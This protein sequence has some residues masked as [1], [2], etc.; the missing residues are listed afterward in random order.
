MKLIDVHSQGGT[1]KRCGKALVNVAL[2]E[3]T[4]NQQT[5]GLD[6]LS[7]VNSGGFADKTEEWKFDRQLRLAKSS[8]RML[9]Q[10]RRA[11]VGGS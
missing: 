7:K 11:K 5:V 1:C 4:E 10:I 6:C 2:V 3:I 8:A 9:A